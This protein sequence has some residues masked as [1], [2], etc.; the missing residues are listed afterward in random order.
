MGHAAKADG[1]VSER[2]ILAARQV[3]RHLRLGEAETREAMD[4]FTRGKA[5]GFDL[6]AT[7]AELR[8][9][10]GGRH[11][12]LRYFLDIQMRT[13]LLGNDLQGPVRP[14]LMRVGPG[15]GYLGLRVRAH[16]GDPA[17]AGLR[18]PPPP[19]LAGRGGGR[20]PAA[21]PARVAD[22]YEIL[23]VKPDCT[24]AELKKA[25]RRQMSQNHPDKLLSRGLPES[26]L[27]IAKEKTQAIQ[28][29]YERIKEAR[30]IN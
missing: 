14:L 26:M 13:A 28:A 6:G 22:A 23:E 9:A 21:R 18:H 3:F 30:G 20:R 8:K 4:C 15:A 1:R 19:V 25:Y 17:H 7:L 16:G 10:C 12:L 5:T 24:E 11:D 2:E 27:E 29:A